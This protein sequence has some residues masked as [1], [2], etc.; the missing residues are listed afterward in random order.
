MR[1]VE[2]SGLGGGPP[3]PKL[4]HGRVLGKL[5]SLLSSKQAPPFRMPRDEELAT[6][7]SGLRYVI[8]A[9]GAGPHPA[10]HESV[11]VRYAGWLA[12]GRPFDASY[13]GTATFGL[14]QVISGW[15]EGLQLLRPGGAATFVSPPELAYGAR[16]APPKIGPGATLVFHVELVRVR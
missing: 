15:T 1:A 9:G 2:Y 16:G 11:T 5:L 6:T 10:P 14:G 4:Y 8:H 12:S 13:P 7:A 3:P